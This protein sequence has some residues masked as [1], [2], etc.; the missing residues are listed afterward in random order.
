MERRFFPAFTCAFPFAEHVFDRIDR[1]L[2]P[3]A[4]AGADQT[5]Q[6]IGQP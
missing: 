1:N 3:T 6:T 4:G 2:H 5:L